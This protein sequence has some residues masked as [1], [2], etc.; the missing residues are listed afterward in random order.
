MAIVPLTEKFENIF[1]II[2]LEQ[3]KVIF[4][5]LQNIRLNRIVFAG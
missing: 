5:I 4:Q 2:L 1:F 3:I